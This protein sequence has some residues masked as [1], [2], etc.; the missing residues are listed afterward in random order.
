M[1][2][3]DSRSASERERATT[4]LLAGFTVVSK[5][6]SKEKKSLKERPASPGLNEFYQRH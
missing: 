5:Q 4:S 2:D 6:E 3:A 1:T